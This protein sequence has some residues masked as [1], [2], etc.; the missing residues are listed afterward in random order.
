MWTTCFTGY[1]R[2][3][4]FLSVDG[5]IMKWLE[6]D[7]ITDHE[8]LAWFSPTFF[9]VI[10]SVRL[11]LK[12]L[13]CFKPLPHHAGWGKSLSDTPGQHLLATFHRVNNCTQGLPQ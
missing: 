1:L 4:S 6:H 9:G 5:E 11:A 3:Y 7:P 8:T 10:L 12:H 2:L 13:R